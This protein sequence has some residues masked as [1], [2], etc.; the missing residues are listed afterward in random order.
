LGLLR[1]DR[2]AREFGFDLVLRGTGLEFEKVTEIRATGR[3]LIVPVDFPQAP[4]V[5]SFADELDVSLTTLRR[6]DWAPSNPSVLEQNGVRF[7]FTT[8][9]LEKKSSFRANVRRAI[10]RGLSERTALAA[11]T[12]IPAE[13]CGVSHLV[14]T[15]EPGKFADFIVCDGNIFDE[16]TSLY[17]VYTHGR[18]KEFIPYDEVSFA[19]Y[20][21]GNLSGKEVGLKIE[22]EGHAKERKVSGKFVVG[23]TGVGLDNV[24]PDRDQLTFSA[25][26]DSLGGQGVARFSVRKEGDRLS[27]RVAFSD[28]SWEAWSVVAAEEPADSTSVPDST[29][30]EEPRKEEK[31]EP[32]VPIA[33]LTF[34]NMAYG[35]ETLPNPENVL[36]K[37]ATI[38]TSEA[39]GVL[40]NSDLLIKNGRIEAIGQN[41]TAPAGVRVIDAT[42]KHVTAGIIDEH[43]HIC[44][45]GD[46]NEG[47]DAISSEVRIGDIV[48]PDD[49]SVYRSLGG[50]VTAARLL[51]GS[52]NPIGG[53]AQIIKLRWGA[54][55]EEMKLKEAPPSIK[56][57][58]GENVKQVNWGEQYT[59]RYPQS[60]MGVETIIRDAFQTTREYEVEWAAY[61]A[62][63]SSQREKTIPPRRNLRLE[64]L[65]EVLHS[66]MFITC[67]AYVQ[68]EILMMMQ[69]AD[70]YGIRIATFGHILE[71]YK[72]AD[73]MARYEAGAGSAPD[74]WAYKFEVY[75]AIPHNPGLLNE[76]G[77]LVSINSDSPNLQRLLNQ[78]AAKS[79]QYT[80][81]SQTDALNM[82]TINPARQ[83]KAEQFIGSLKAGKHADFVIWSGNPLS[84][85]S[86]AEQ[87]WIDGKKYFDIEEDAG[88]RAQ[89][90]EEKNKLIQ[91]ILAKPGEGKNDKGEGRPGG[92]RPHTEGGRHENSR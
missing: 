80:G 64:A 54:T 2:I 63:S 38:W 60:R 70:D 76:R 5:K 26:L 18:K 81:M 23:E 66:R 27:G 67:H 17:S 21:A 37:N 91:K 28:G 56:F 89:V 87:T 6:W 86:R 85:Y 9:R 62:L 79:V 8:D 46:V 11:L 73:E 78:A 30:S 32:D 71:G 82:V 15:L 14:G 3:T 31:E 13:V 51:H 45:S 84:V 7:A 40:G 29:K 88:L 39:E 12:T 1:A 4:E 68:S 75:D 59:V 48:D 34:P 90:I 33:R 44:I 72:V 19:G 65:V 57:A 77:V 47:T 69:L 58:L 10:K 42:G 41:L 43:S 52:A 16:E 50:G 25:A 92:H 61:N 55:A 36:V 74:W 49:I 53:Q 24:K 20:Y 83:L 35:F 22:D